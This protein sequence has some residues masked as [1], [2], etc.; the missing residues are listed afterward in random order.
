MLPLTASPKHMSHVQSRH[1]KTNAEHLAAV[2]NIVM[3]EIEIGVARA[4]FRTI[5]KP[6]MDKLQDLLHR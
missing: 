3:T 1:C 6:N 5:D 4:V 2:K